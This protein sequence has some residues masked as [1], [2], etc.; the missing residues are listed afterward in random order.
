MLLSELAAIVAKV[1]AEL[2]GQGVNGCDLD[3]VVWVNRRPVESAVLQGNNQLPPSFM[4]TG[5]A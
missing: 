4:I 3:P 5:K 2:K 1:Q